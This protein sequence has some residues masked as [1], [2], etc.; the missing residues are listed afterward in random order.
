MLTA[1]FPQNIV[2][3]FLYCMLMIVVAF[4]CVQLLERRLLHSTY[5]L[6]V[7]SVVLELHGLLL[8]FIYYFQFARDGKASSLLKMFGRCFAGP[9]GANLPKSLA[10]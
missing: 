6:F 3:L 4:Q 9:S 8:L 5:K 2:S 1:V 10:R 7:L